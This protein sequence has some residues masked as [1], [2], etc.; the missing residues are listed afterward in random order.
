MTASAV[1]TKGIKESSKESRVVRARA[2]SWRE[3]QAGRASCGGNAPT[4]SCF[5]IKITIFCKMLIS[6]EGSHL[7]KTAKMRDFAGV[8]DE[9]VPLISLVGGGN[10]RRVL[11]I[12]S[13]DND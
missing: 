9:E 1:R 4:D 2:I 6:S 5:L 10:S 3:R 12:L 11:S 13:R 7:R 8:Y